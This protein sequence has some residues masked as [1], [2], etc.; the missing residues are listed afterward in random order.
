MSYGEVLGDKSTMHIRV[1]LFW[2]HLIVLWLFHLDVSFT[3]FV[4]TCFV[5]CVCVCVCVCFDN[6]VGV[7]VICVLVFNVFCI[8]CTVFFV[9][10]R[11][12][13][14]IFVFSVLM[15]GL[16]PPSDNSIAVG[17][18]SSSR[19]RSNNNNNNNNNRAMKPKWKFRT[20]TSKV[21]RKTYAYIHLLQVNSE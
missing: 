21:W 10:F 19:S 20:C 12:C 16:L 11:L 18:S 3:V 7:L 2:G 17:S 9:L 8:V 1:T 4:L 6:S 14:F 15:Y 13:I 5:M